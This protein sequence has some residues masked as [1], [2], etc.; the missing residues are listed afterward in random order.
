MGG[1]I[2]R[3]EGA[4]GLGKWLRCG[5]FW[6]LRLFSADLQVT[7][8]AMSPSCGTHRDK[9]TPFMQSRYGIVYRDEYRGWWTAPEGRYV[10]G[11]LQWRKQQ[12]KRVN[13]RAG[14]YTHLSKPRYTKMTGIW[15]LVILGG[16][17]LLFRSCFLDARW[18]EV[19]RL[20]PAGFASRVFLSF[21][22]S[23]PHALPLP[24]TS[25]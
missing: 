1:C 6:E 20:L 2:G 13:G 9:D 5:S 14:A 3:P 23:V 22:T 11:G 15:D 25:P 7:V 21:R 19:K 16:H 24:P 10:I 4:K 18:L 8:P 12:R 17:R